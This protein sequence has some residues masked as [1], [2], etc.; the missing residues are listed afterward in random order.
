MS[1]LTEAWR[2]IEALW[3]DKTPPCVTLVREKF[4]QYDALWKNFVLQHHKLME[5]VDV[6]EHGQISE[7]FNILAQQRIN[8]AASVEKFICNAVTELNEHVMQDSQEL[9]KPSRRRSRGSRSRRSSNSCSSSKT[10]A[11]RQKRLGW[12]S[13]SWK[14]RT[15]GKSKLK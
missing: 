6:T 7:Q 15:N 1:L 5:F 10:Q 13:P 11:L 3:R 9:T 12:L 14:K 2:E 8:L 4:N